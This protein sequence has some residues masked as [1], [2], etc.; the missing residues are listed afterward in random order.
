MFYTSALLLTLSVSSPSVN[1]LSKKIPTF[2]KAWATGLCAEHLKQDATS[3]KCAVDRVGR[4]ENRVLA[5][6]RLKDETDQW[7]AWAMFTP[8]GKQVATGQW[9]TFVYSEVTIKSWGDKDGDGRLDVGT[10]DVWGEGAERDTS[11]KE[12]TRREWNGKD[13]VDYEE[14]KAQ[15]PVYVLTSQGLLRDG[16]GGRVIQKLRIATEVVPYSKAGKWTWVRAGKRYGM[17][18]E[19]VLSETKPTLTWLVEQYEAASEKDFEQRLTWAERAAALAPQSAD[20][21]ARLAQ[22]LGKKPE[23]SDRR[24]KV[25]AALKKLKASE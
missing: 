25:E 20:A 9:K 1:D 23:W 7:I 16:P 24:R 5:T 10:Y 4:F 15:A 12:N 18:H 2:A 21:L 17:L 6:A 11:G 22:A 13:F 14:S 8:K 3:N 19:T